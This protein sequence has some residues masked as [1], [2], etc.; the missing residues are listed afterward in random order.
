M[1]LNVAT[2]VLL[3]VIV[4]LQVVPVAVSQPVQPTNVEPAEGVAVRLRA[5]PVSTVAVQAA[6]Q[7]IAPP[8]TVPVPVPPFWTVSVYRMGLNVAMTVALAFIVMV[9]VVPV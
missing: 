5:V 7:L 4:T 1:G 8:V 6:P 9:Q 3:A 2:T